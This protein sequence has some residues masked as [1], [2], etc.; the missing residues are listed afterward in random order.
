M[1]NI[2]QGYCTLLTVCRATLSLWASHYSRIPARCLQFA[3][4]YYH[5]VHNDIVPRSAA[6]C[7][8]CVVQ[9]R[10][11]VRHCVIQ[12]MQNI[13]HNLKHSIVMVHLQVRF[14]TLRL[15]SWC[16]QYTHD[17]LCSKISAYD[18]LQ[19]VLDALVS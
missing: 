9:L 2:L 8:Q 18:S 3:V 14:H 1:D 13:V 12:V 16:M 19:F 11:G 15:S 5:G 7:A 4:R 17:S 6:H 10:H